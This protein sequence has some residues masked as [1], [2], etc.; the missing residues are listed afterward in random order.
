MLRAGGKAV[1][2]KIHRYDSPLSRCER[3]KIQGGV[4]L[5]LPPHSKSNQPVAQ[6]LG[7]RLGLRMHL[8]FLVD[9]LQMKVDGGGS[10]SQLCSSGFVVVP[11]DQQL[12]DAD[13]VR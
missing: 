1:T 3:E 10:D 5:S 9:V 12:Q 11:F 2:V 6:C 7:H 13:L 4:A 8:Q